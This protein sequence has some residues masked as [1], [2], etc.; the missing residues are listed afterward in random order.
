[1]EHA[2]LDL[3]VAQESS[4]TTWV[5]PDLVYR[6]YEAVRPALERRGLRFGNITFEPYEG[7]AEGTILR[8]SPLPGH[9]LRRTEAIA[10]SVSTGVGAVNG[11]GVGDRP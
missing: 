8:Q 3:L 5:M 10:L 9:P 2:D 4:G 7:I 11:S 6:R 1:M